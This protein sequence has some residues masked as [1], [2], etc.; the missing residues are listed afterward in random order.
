MLVEYLGKVRFGP[1]SLEPH[2][3]NCSPGRSRRLNRTRY[4]YIVDKESGI[5][6][7][8]NKDSKEKRERLKL[9]NR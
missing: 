9:K 4:G 2:Y 7:A 6:L 3:A 8:C 5:L 1:R